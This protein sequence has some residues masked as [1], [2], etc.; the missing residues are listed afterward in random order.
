MSIEEMMRV[1]ALD[2]MKV[3]TTMH[4]AALTSKECTGRTLGEDREPLWVEDSGSSSKASPTSKKNSVDS[5]PNTFSSYDTKSNNAKNVTREKE[6][7]AKGCVLQQLKALSMT[8]SEP[9]ISC[10]PDAQAINAS[11]VKRELEEEGKRCVRQQLKALKDKQDALRLSRESQQKEDERQREQLQQKALRERNDIL[12]IQKADQMT[13]AQLEAQQREQLALRQQTD[14]KLHKLALEGVS[15]CQRRFNQ[16]YEG[17]ARILLS[18]DKETVQ[19]CS[20]QN[21]Q[22]KELGQK[23]EHLVSTVKM[24]KCEMQSQYLC[25][26][27]KAEECCKSL[28]TLELEIIKQLAEFS[29]QIQ[30]Q[31]KMEAAKKLEEERQKQLDEEKQRR[32][33]EETEA[34]E[35]QQQL[36]EAAKAE[37]AKAEAAKVPIPSE[38]KSQD[39][40]PDATATTS[41]CVHPD[42][43][44]FYNE[45]LSLY[46]TK[47]DAVKPLQTEESL[48][49]YRTGCQRA[50][51]LPLNAISAV[52]PQHLSQNFDKLYSF[53]AGQPV[54]VMNGAS[55]TINDHP[56]ARDYC[57]LLMAK[58]FVSQTETAISSNPQAAFPFA[59]VIVTF[60]K[61][62]PDFGKVFL[63]YMYKESPFLVPYVIPQQPG[64]TPE[65]YLKT[66]GY[67]LSEKNE[68]EKPDMYLKRQTGIARLYAAVIIT[69]GRKAAGNDQCF[70][71]EEGWVWLTHMVN[72]KPLPD[73]SATMIMEILQTLGFEL[74][75]TYGKQ[76][77]KLLVYIQNIYMPQ[78]AAY[79]EGGPKTRL[80]MLLAKFLRERQIPQAVGILPPGFW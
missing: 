34:K 73:I 29:E 59:S 26:I 43:L 67:R 80:E 76:F 2:W 38:P 51:N 15:R 50:I 57:M 31:L 23:F 47:V 64:Q 27:I 6:E 54:K 37:A 7:E 13:T 24:G 46:Q 62:L 63:A 41:S 58:K 16:K 72:V 4:H 61:L 53:F 79:D 33:K 9:S 71:L 55:I 18:L 19:V 1:Q 3:K 14:Q 20:T 70:E 78:L 75:R 21:T 48:K 49:Q 42:R 39:V 35:K 45:I 40:P 68:L 25:S 60:W 69:Q 74:W 32:E 11:I 66:I 8:D 56:L 10:F 22:L 36:A 65:Q 17:I 30:Q 28:D 44:K 77:V 12:L 52:S 5:E